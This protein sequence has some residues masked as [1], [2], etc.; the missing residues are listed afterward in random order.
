[1]NKYKINL[2][3]EKLSEK[4]IVQQMDFDKF[5][6]DYVAKPSWMLNGIK[7]YTLIGTTITAVAIAGF[8]IYKT[9]ELNSD[10]V[11]LPFINPPLKS[12]DIP[13]ESYQVNMDKDTTILFK[14]GSIIQVP[15]N[16]FIDSNG[17]NVSGVVDMNYREFHDPIEIMLSGIPMNYDSAGTQYQFESAGMLEISAFQHN[18]PL[19]LKP[20][21]QLSVNMVSAASGDNYNIY[22]LDTA[23][24]CWNYILENT[25]ENK[26]CQKIFDSVPPSKSYASEV[27]PEQNQMPQKPSKA[28]PDAY[29]FALD[30]DKTEFPELTVYDG[31]KFEITPDDKVF[32][33]ELAKQTWDDVYIKRHPDNE[34]YIVTFS[35][36]KI[37]HSFAVLPVFEEKN[38]DEALKNYA[39]KLAQY[40]TMLQKRKTRETTRGDSLY[41]IKAIF[42]GKVPQTNLNERFN[43]F[44][45]GNFMAA[46]PEKLVYRTLVISKMGFWNCDYPAAYFINTVSFNTAAFRI[47]NRL[48][49]DKIVPRYSASFSD[50]TGTPL[51]LKTVF[52]FR[53]DFNGVYAIN[54]RAF[55]RFPF[56]Q[57]HVDKMVGITYDNKVVYLTKA[58]FGSIKINS[59]SIHFQLQETSSEIKTAEQLKQLLKI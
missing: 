52:L 30:Y 9:S 34:H 46:S 15:A 22:Y 47:I 21:K 19:R 36:E 23:Q 45:A 41:R 33:P 6:S 50:K 29:D 16:S 20:G 37:S 51:I 32:N 57:E 4:E 35:S 59:N 39:T 25:Y 58:D 31:I 18:K 26:T 53:D 1:M 7:L 54:E 44:V 56:D 27:S 10:M 48:K 14:T 17:N 2:N 40:Q 38:Y 24:K 3:Q 13:F 49:I 8:L 12:M 5:M 43:N 28:N 42:S 55:A 11:P